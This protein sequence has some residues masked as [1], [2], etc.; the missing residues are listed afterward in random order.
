M[1]QSVTS[2]PRRMTDEDVHYRALSMTNEDAKSLLRH[3]ESL[4]EQVLEARALART[5]YDHSVFAADSSEVAIDAQAKFEK[6]G[7]R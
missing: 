5:C 1:S 3:C 2:D 7:M 6:W 4:K